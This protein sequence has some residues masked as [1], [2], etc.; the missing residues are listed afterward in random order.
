MKNK[1][2]HKTRERLYKE[3][4]AFDLLT[5]YYHDLAHPTKSTHEIPRITAKY[6]SALSLE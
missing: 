6:L 3:T 4:K 5:V 2:P 1:K